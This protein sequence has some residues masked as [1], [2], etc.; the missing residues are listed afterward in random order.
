MSYHQFDKREFEVD[1]DDH[2]QEP[3]SIFKEN[4]SSSILSYK[5]HLLVDNLC[6][7]YRTD[8]NTI[9]CSIGFQLFD[10]IGIGIIIIIINRKSFLNYLKQ[11]ITRSL[12]YTKKKKH[13]KTDF[14]NIIITAIFCQIF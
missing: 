9:V 6:S 14:F 3:R 10:F 12:I 1:R 13:Y 8:N 5:Y 4:I 11:S 2:C 7:T